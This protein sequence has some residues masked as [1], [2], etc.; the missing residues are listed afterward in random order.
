MVKEENINDMIYSKYVEYSL[1]IKPE[2]SDKWS[3][4][5]FVINKIESSTAFTWKT[6]HLYC[7]SNKVTFLLIIK[8]FLKHNINIKIIG[9][10]FEIS[11]IN[12]SDKKVTFRLSFN[13]YT[14]NYS[15]LKFINEL[16]SSK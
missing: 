11:E 6:R 13:K 8:E 10:L 5:D 2:L 12:V 14:K 9:L 7:E 16:K 3:K 1:N 15:I 4:K